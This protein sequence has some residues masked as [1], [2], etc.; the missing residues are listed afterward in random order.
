LNNNE[1]IKI[2][3]F[4]LCI[5]NTLLCSFDGI[6]GGVGKLCYMS[7]EL[8]LG[9]QFNAIKSDIWSLGTIL[10]TMLTGHP[11]YKKP[12]VN[13]PHFNIIYSGKLTKYISQKK[14]LYMSPEALDLLSHIF[15]EESKRYTTEQILNH[16]WLAQIDSNSDNNLSKSNELILDD[17]ENIIDESLLKNIQ[18]QPKWKNCVCI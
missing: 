15:C 16:P 10:F 5:K 7:P 17:N 9:K 11:P 3:D 18:K 14:E 13:D 6:T 1:E 8:W 4:D 2:V 12:S